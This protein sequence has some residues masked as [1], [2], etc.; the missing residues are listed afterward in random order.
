MF[1]GLDLPASSAITQEALGWT[2]SG[3]SLL[4]DL[5]AGHY[6]G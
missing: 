4:A 5:E 6:T 2:P 1:F 3:P